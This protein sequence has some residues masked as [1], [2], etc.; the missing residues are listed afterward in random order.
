LDHLK[1]NGLFGIRTPLSL[2]PE[3]PEPRPAGE[4]FALDSPPHLGM[5]RYRRDFAEVERWS[6]SESRMPRGGNSS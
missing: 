5:R 3:D 4:P 6:R 2:G 1:V